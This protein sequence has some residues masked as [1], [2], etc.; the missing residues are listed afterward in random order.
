MGSDVLANCKGAGFRV[1]SSENP[2]K[3]WLGF[4]SV[5]KVKGDLGTLARAHK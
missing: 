3:V 5:R 1:L 2:E 4:E